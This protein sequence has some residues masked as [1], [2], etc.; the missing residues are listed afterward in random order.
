MP[1]Y[2][3]VFLDLRG[4]RCVVVGGG[5]VAER[6]VRVLLEHDASIA[7]VSPTLSQGLQELAE[8]GTIQ[9]VRREFGKGDLAGAFLAIAATGDADINVAVAAEAREQR[10][11]VN[12][13]DDPANSDFIVPSLVRR[14]D[15]SVAISTAGKS[16]ALARK[17][18]TILE[19]NLP[20]EY[21]SLVGVVADVREELSRRGVT[22]DADTWQQCLDIDVLLEMVG[23][24]ESEEARQ[25]LIGC[26]TDAQPSLAHQ[27]KGQQ[28]H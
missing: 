8:Q 23:R 28:F 26:L 24:G 6:K 7:V 18:R 1:G 10:A 11:L 4:K 2:Y 14:G 5:S 13:V 12:V 21:A 25:M 16:P 19:A 9:A 22:V 20:P 17:L 15:I 3:P 27:A